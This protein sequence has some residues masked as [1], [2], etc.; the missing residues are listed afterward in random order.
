ML[1]DGGQFYV[2]K[3]CVSIY[4]NAVIPLADIL[5]PNQTELE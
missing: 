4:Q 1:G 3:E 5:T 2:P